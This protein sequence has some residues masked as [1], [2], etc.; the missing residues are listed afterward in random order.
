[1]RRCGTTQCR[2]RRLRMR[3]ACRLHTTIASALLGY[4]SPGMIRSH[5]TRCWHASSESADHDIKRPTAGHRLGYIEHGALRHQHGRC[6]FSH[7]RQRCRVFYGENRRRGDRP[8]STIQFA[9]PLN[10][11]VPETRT[12]HARPVSPPRPVVRRGTAPRTHRRMNGSR[13]ARSSR[14]PR[15]PPCGQ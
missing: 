8:G 15:P 5:W 13:P 12:R 4:R 11:A 10:D 7:G 6:S 14:A 2:S 3:C 9:V 1:M